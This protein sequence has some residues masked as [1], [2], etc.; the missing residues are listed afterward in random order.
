[1]KK[2]IKRDGTYQNYFPYKIED[3]IRKAFEATNVVYDSSVFD[4]VIN[5]FKK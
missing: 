2:V 3:A 5:N 4:E 1:M